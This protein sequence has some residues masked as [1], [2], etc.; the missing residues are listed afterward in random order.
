M[1]IIAIRHGEVPLN[2]E[3]KLTGWLDVDLN[4]K[5]REQAFSMAQD[6]SGAFDTI[7]ASPLL[8]TASTAKIIAERHPCKIVFDPNLRERNFGSLN[9]KTWA[10]VEL[11]TG[12][13]LRHID[14]DLLQYD[15]RPYG[16]ESV[17]QV[18][19]RVEQF[20]STA[21]ANNGSGDLV[22]VTHGGVIR[23][24]YSLLAPGPRKPIPNCSVHIFHTQSKA[25]QSQTA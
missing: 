15:Y 24:L 9:G 22:V 8:R 6:L 18:T 10:E 4:S 1:R 5:G 11:E 23:I 17:A 12:K 2:A 19:A 16:G 13:D 7:V 3:D 20:L 21:P 25:S 14:I